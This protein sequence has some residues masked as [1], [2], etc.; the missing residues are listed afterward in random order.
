[1]HVT[2]VHVHVKPESLEAFVAATRR[3]HEGSLREP[4]NLRFDVL[5]SEDEPSRFVLVEIFRDAEAAVA[6]KQTPH[7][8]AWRDEVAAWMAAP[9]EGKRY[10]MLAPLAARP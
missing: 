8:L 4:G 9:R 5:Q 3:N 2:L 6:H 7:Y 1:M 10:R